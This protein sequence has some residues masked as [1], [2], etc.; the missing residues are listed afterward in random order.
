MMYQ[1]LASSRTGGASAASACASGWWSAASSIG[2]I[3]SSAML[4]SLSG[5]CGEELVDDTG[6]HLIHYREVSRERKHGYDHD[7][8][9]GAHLLPGR[10]RD[11]AHFQLQL[12]KIVL[13]LH[14]PSRRPLD[15][16]PGFAF[17][18]LCRHLASYFLW[19]LN[20]GRG[21]GTRT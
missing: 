13:H 3:S 9:S 10:P 16:V 4:F 12:F 6:N 18:Y 19:L 11:A 21:R 5:K 7:Q 20:S 2:V 14:R 17:L 1:F 8:C 15:E